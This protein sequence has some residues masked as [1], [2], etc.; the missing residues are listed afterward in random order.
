MPF[1]GGVS[2][3]ALSFAAVEVLKTADMAPGAWRMLIQCWAPSRVVAIQI[4]K[5]I[6]IQ[7]SKAV[8]TQISKKEM[9]LLFIY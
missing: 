2:A 8:G 1:G 6:A 4:S 5:V 7:F 9:Y 3:T